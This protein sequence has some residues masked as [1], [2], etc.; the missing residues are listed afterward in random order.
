MTTIDELT[1]TA[2]LICMEFIW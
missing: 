2:G 1:V